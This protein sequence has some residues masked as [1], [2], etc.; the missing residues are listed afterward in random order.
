MKL[1]QAVDT[2]KDQTFF[3][4]QV[5]Q[6]ALR[7]TMF[8]IGSMLKRDVK[9]LAQDIGLEAVAQKRES[10]GICFV[11]KRNF[12]DFMSDYIAPT[13]GDFVNIET[14]EIVGHHRGIHN[15][16]IGQRVLISGQREGLFAVRKMPDKKTIL[17]APGTNHPAMFCDLFYTETPHWIDKSP[18]NGNSVANVTFRFQ[19]G[20]KLKVCD[21]VETEMGLLAKLSEPVRAVCAGQFAVFYKIGECIGSAKISATGPCIKETVVRDE[22][23]TSSEF[24]AAALARQVRTEYMRDKNSESEKEVQIVIST[25]N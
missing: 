9:Q 19:H 16:T 8:P 1:L 17:V 24:D 2:R 7:H 21:L 13:P 5:P 10:V 15:Y 14:G 22:V 4:S 25:R 18:F 6:N 23:A 11:G 12:S 20:H 3:L